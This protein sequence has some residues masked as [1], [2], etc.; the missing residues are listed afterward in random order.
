MS[1][2]SMGTRDPPPQPSS[3]PLIGDNP[4]TSLPITQPARSQRPQR[5]NLRL[6]NAD[7]VHSR[8]T[9]QPPVDYDS[10][11][12]PPIESSP[13][14]SSQTSCSTKDPTSS[15]ADNTHTLD[16]S[17]QHG[18]LLQSKSKQFR[19]AWCMACSTLFLSG[20]STWYVWV[21]FI[22]ENS[23]PQ[24]LALSPGRTLLVIQIITHVI[25]FMVWQII[26]SA[27]EFL[28]WT[29]ATGA[30]GISIPA[31]FAMSRATSLLGVASL[32]LMG[33]SHR[34][35]CVSRSVI[36]CDPVVLYLD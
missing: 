1:Q 23:V 27:L 32:C 3:T 14:T 8:Y 22:S 31:F 17:R 4:T 34:F 29:L 12:A 33:G 30:T 7:E 36:Q 18:V 28:R 15:K 24:A 9:S 10:D 2:T 11:Q 19:I 16:L 25:A 13:A 26:E 20:F 6:S 35:W 5:P 21:V